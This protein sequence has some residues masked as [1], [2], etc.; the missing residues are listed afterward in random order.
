[1]TRNCSQKGNSI[2][3]LMWKLSS[4]QEEF[5]RFLQQH[6]LSAKDEYNFLH[7]QVKKEIQVRCSK[8]I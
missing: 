8:E 3:N 2:Q 6:S 7:L 5:L 4:E 1:M